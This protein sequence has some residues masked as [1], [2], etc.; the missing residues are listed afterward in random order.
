VGS[1]VRTLSAA[2]ALAL[3][4]VAF[5]VAPARADGD[6]ASDILLIDNVFLTY[7]VDVSATA[8]IA[9]EQTVAKLN[10]TGF[11]VK[12]AVIADPADLGAVPSLFGKPQIYAKFLGTEIAFQ[13][14]NRLLV[15]MPNG[16]GFW[17][18]RKPIVR[19]KKILAKLTVKQGGDGLARSAVTALKALSNPRK[20]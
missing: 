19:E 20:K 15:V 18:N 6:P 13:Y 11:R 9:L 16:Y 3:A 5:G 12:V 1:F 17:R 8:K 14:T 7:S 2:L 4:T 10:R